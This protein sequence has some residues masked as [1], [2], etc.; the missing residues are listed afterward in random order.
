[1]KIFTPARRRASFTL[2]EL[3]VVIAIIAILA[4]ILVPVAG[5]A[6]KSALK[7][8]AMVEMNSIKVA[9]LEFQRDHG[10]M[11]W[12]PT[13]VQNRRIWIGDDMWT[14]GESDQLEVMELLT[15]NNP[16][17]KV[18]LQI[19]EKSRPSVTSMVFLDP[20]RQPYR[21]GLD[22]NLDGA[23]LPDATFGGD[24]VRENVLV[25]SLGDPNE[26]LVVP[27]KTFD[28]PH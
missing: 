24:Y 16:M 25:Y 5:K 6:R 19:P 20:W 11:P 17:K 23:I 28:L 21:I 10:F 7:K 26:D 13:T 9:V 3:L 2:V 15:G 1:M 14:A 22:R 4:A 27:L 18:Y 12:P 8:R